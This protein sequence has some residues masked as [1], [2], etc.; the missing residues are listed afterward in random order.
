MTETKNKET[1]SSFI[2]KILNG[3]TIAIVVAL[4]PNAI[5]ATFL[6]PIASN[7]IA[8]NFLHIVQIFQFFT[9]I[10]AG[11]LIAMQFKFN[12]IQSACVGGAAY[13]GSGAWKF[14]EV[15]MSGE[16]KNIFQLAGIGD[17]INTML[18]AALAVL[19]VQWIGNKLGSLNLVFLPIIVGT[20]VGFIGTLTLPY[21]SM[22]TSVIGQG[23]NSFTTL[24][25]ILM[26][27]LIA[28]SFSIIIISPISTVAIGLA[29]GLDGLA[30]ASAGMGV[31]AAA[32]FL[33]W[34]TMRRNGA[35]VPIAIGLGAM[36]MMMPNFLTNPIIGLPVAI[37]AAISAISIPIIGMVGTPASAG[38][39]LVGLVSP[40]AA[41]NGGGINVFTM[42]LTWIV[43]PFG[44]GF[45]VNKVMCD[46][47]HVYDD[48]IFVFKG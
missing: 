31:A 45:I 47:L 48:E 14:V 18:T 6:K 27:I 39:G 43:I 38:F 35:G 46:V 20:G 44:V 10:M 11:F 36:K 29:I 2:L 5:L 3:T 19:L 37:T 9:P 15:A 8:A 4:I 32:A 21:V 23:I 41:L 26:S 34:A 22:I 24:Q 40:L 1:V 12:P 28:I 13:I 33:V 17:V 42:I 16:T 25:P 7:E 30:S